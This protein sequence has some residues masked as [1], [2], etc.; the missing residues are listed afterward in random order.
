MYV[1]G[2]VCVCVCLGTCVCGCMCGS[3]VSGWVGTRKGS[4]FTHWTNPRFGPKDQTRETV[5]KFSFD[6][7]FLG[8][9]EI[10]PAMPLE[11]RE[12]WQSRMQGPGAN[13]GQ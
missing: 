9:G 11:G 10:A 6:V 2:R 4:R 13:P 5:R 1:G 7:F 12:R 3:G 8:G